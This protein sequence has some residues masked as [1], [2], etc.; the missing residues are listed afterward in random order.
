[1]GEELV[2]RP[3]GPGDVAALELRMPTGRNRTH[4][5]RYR[6]QRE[7]GSTFLVA[8]LGSGSGPA[9]GPV[10]SGEVIWAGAKETDVRQRFP[11]CPEINGLAVGPEWQSHGVGT[12]IVR[13][14]EEHA[15]RRGCRRIGLGVDEENVRAAALYRR[16][17][18]RDTGCRYLDRY[19]YVDEHGTR[20]DVADPCR[21]LIKA[22]Q[23]RP[24]G[25]AGA[26]RAPDGH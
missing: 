10:G 6:R 23:G 11:G 3:C 24:A 12:A 1:M 9:T 18:Y 22:I 21:F 7:G 14:A 25:R 26:R 17:G 8:W 19:Q 16:L 4:A 15:A 13:A 2:V 5:V 20:H